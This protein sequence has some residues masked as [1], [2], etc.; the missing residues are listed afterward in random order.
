MNKIVIRSILLILILGLLLLIIFLNRSPFGRDNSSFAS[1]PKEQITR[2]E[3]SGERKSLILEQKGETWYINGKTEARKS[4]IQF[5][6]RILKEIKI[7][8]PVSQELFISEI[9][10]KKISPVRVKVY[11]NHRLLKS[12]LVYKTQ[13]NTYGNIM[14][15]R[16]SSKPFIVFVPGYDGNIGSAFNLNE[17]FWQSYTVFNFLPSEIAEVRLDN[18]RDTA[19]SFAII[20]RKKH[21]YLTGIGSKSGLDSSLVV[22]Y[23]SYFA[24]VPFESW[25]FEMGENEKR[26]VEARQ[27]LYTITVSTVAGSRK[28]LKLWS[29]MKGEGDN[30]TVDSDRLLGKSDESGEFFIMRY[31]DIDPLI[32]KRSYFF[33]E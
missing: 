8:S 2:I 16:E 26:S 5:I 17:I 32:K 29:M 10:G 12:F 19:S 13:A 31:F 1:E 22:R 14:K 25:A 18:M 24:Y 33:R 21:F 30:K 9:A 20:N 27:P 23:I 7:K 11:E 15:M 4:G 3:L 6:T 28:V